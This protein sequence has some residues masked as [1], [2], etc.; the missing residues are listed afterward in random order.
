[1][2]GAGRGRYRPADTALSALRWAERRRDGEEAGSPARARY[3]EEA[4]RLRDEYEVRSADAGSPATPRPSPIAARRA[5]AVA[6][7]LPGTRSGPV[8]ARPS[9]GPPR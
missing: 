6:R 9:P 3:E 2:T 7:A 1:M 8:P 5:A 4:R